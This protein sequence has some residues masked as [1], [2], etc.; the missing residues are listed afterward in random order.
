[1]SA[2]KRAKRGGGR[3]PPDP[4]WRFR[5]SLLGSKIAKK[6]EKWHPKKHR[7]NYHHKTRTLMPKGCQNGAKINV[8]THQKSM[9]KHVVSCMREIMKNPPTLRS[10]VLEHVCGGRFPPPY[11]PP[12][13][14]LSPRALQ[15]SDPFGLNW[16]K[17]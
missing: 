10:G 1:M 8:K 6:R 2:P 15:N 7:K 17:V 14:G 3:M 13:W 9:R 11:P 5:G 12:P 4:R 16:P